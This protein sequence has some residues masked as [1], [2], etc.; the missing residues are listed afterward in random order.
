MLGK[1]AIKFTKYAVF[2]TFSEDQRYEQ[3]YGDKFVT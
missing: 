2:E 1:T 3:Y